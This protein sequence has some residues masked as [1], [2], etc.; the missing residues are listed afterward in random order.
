MVG[1][2]TM[3]LCW[4]VELALNTASL[5]KKSPASLKGPGRPPGHIVHNLFIFCGEAFIIDISVIA[6]CDYKWSP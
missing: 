6:L 3:T 2:L 1:A 4:T 5:E